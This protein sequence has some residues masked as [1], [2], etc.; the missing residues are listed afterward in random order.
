MSEGAVP[1]ADEWAIADVIGAFYAAALGDE[2]WSAA[3]SRLASLL[4]G[5]GVTL[6]QI[7]APPAAMAAPV[8]DGMLVWAEA[9]PAGLVTEI[10]ISRS[11]GRSR[12]G[13]DDITLLRY[14]GPHLGRALQLDRGFATAPVGPERPAPTAP[15]LLSQREQDCLVWV[16]RGAT[17]KHAARQLNLSSHT[18][19]EHV[20]SAMAKLGVSKRTEAAALAVAGGLIAT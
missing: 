19:D 3:L 15:R 4:G 1:T 13:E 5:E 7:D 17:S 18:V 20:R 6:T 11:S 16:A 10:A 12:W 2:T 9:D 8:P 14:L